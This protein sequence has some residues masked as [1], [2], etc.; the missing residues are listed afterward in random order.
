VTLADPDAA[1]LG[2]LRRHGPARCH[3]AITA[4]P[5]LDNAISILR[6][7]ASCGAELA[8]LQIKTAG[9]LHRYELSVTQLP[10]AAAD[11]LAARIASLPGVVSANLER[12]RL[13]FEKAEIRA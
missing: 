11:D 7:I 10:F 9:A 5:Q 6:A 1:E 2:G 3:Y 13:D 12:L 4:L 8:A